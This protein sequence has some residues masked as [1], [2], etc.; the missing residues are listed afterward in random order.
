MIDKFIEK[1]LYFFLRKYILK[2][3][4]LKK[5]VKYSL[6][7]IVNTA[8]DFSIYIALT[9]LIPWFADNYLIANAI[10]FTVAVTNSFILNKRWT[11]KYTNKHQLHFQYFKFVIVNLFTL[12]I[13]ELALYILV[14]QFGVYDL[15]AK[16]VITCFGVVINFSLSRFW[17]FR[18]R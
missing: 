3:P 5:F 16:I 11:F 18:V 17:V 15:F 6:V 8:I 7:G 9:R 2:F 1:V 12:T 4:S 14:S 13:V 10:S